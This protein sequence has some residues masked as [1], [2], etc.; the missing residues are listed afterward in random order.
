MVLNNIVIIFASDSKFQGEK[1]GMKPLENRLLN[2]TYNILRQ[3][4]LMTDSQRARDTQPAEEKQ[5]DRNQHIK[6]DYL[7]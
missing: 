2:F 6:S 5:K 4:L 7:A 3:N 1:D